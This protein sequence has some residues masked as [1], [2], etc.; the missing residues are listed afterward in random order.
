LFLASRGSSTSVE[1][2]RYQRIKWAHTVLEYDFLPH[3]STQPDGF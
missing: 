2:R 3:V 1:Q